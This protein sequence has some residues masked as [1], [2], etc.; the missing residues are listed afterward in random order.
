MT[1]RN[2]LAGVAVRDLDKAV[3]WYT[4]LIGRSPDRRPMPNDAEYAFEKGG[5]MQIFVDKE[6]AGRSSVT[7]VVDDLDATLAELDAAGIARAE[8]TRTDYVD[9]AILADPD[10]N[11]IVVAQAKSQEHG[12]AR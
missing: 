3:N 12:R 11:Q 6:R 4:K 7:L 10:G 1:I 5:W 8:P 9:I 2:A